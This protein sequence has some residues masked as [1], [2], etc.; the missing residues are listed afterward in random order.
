MKSLHEK[1]KLHTDEEE[2]SKTSKLLIE[3]DNQRYSLFNE[4]DTWQ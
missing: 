1:L 2:L 3:L 4:I